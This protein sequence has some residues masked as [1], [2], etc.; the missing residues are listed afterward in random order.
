MLR[1]PE[2]PVS[3]SVI[4]EMA[5][6]AKMAE[7]EYLERALEWCIENKLAVLHIEYMK[8][9]GFTWPHRIVVY[10]PKSKQVVKLKVPFS[11]H[12]RLI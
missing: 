6:Q 8:S 2:P 11:F 10:D 7:V 3:M 5:F 4:D 9:L 12:T 1:S